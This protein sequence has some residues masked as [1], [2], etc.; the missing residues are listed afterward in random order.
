MQVGLLPPAAGDPAVP[1]ARVIAWELEI[2]GSHGMAAH[3]YPPM[4][5]RIRTGALRPHLLV[6]S[7]I[8]LA[9][10][11][12]ALAAM[13]TAPGA[14]WCHDHRTVERARRTGARWDGR[15]VSG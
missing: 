1:M 3:D 14:A 6:T 5:E 11:P 13:G 15:P 12:A 9:E 7:T 2:L 10:A 4:M 8:G